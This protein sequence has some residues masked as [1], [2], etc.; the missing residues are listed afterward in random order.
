MVMWDRRLLL[1]KD[2]FVLGRSPPV[3]ASVSIESH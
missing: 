1:Y 3:H 2:I